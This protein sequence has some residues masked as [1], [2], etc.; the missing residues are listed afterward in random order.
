MSRISIRVAMGVSVVESM[1]SQEGFGGGGGRRGGGGGGRRGGGEAVRCG[2]A[3]GR[4][5]GGAEGTQKLQC[6]WRHK[7]KNLQ[8]LY[9]IIRN[10]AIQSGI[11]VALPAWP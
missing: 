2:D 11:P 5:R 3:E 4:R 1:P 9:G 7:L 8:P 6:R 10:L